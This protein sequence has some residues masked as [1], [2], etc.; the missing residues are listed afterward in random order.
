MAPSTQSQSICYL[1][2]VQFQQVDSRPL[3]L[4]YYN[5]ANPQ[6]PLVGPGGNGTTQFTDRTGALAVQVVAG[7]AAATGNQVT[8]PTTSGW[9]PA[10]VITVA[11]GQTS[12]GAVN[13]AVHPLAPFLASLTSQ[14]HLGIP[15][16]APKV[17]LSKEVQGLLPGSAIATDTSGI[18][19]GVNAEKLDGYRAADLLYNGSFG[20]PLQTGGGLARDN[21]GALGLVWD[22]GTRQ[23]AEVPRADHVHSNDAT[24]GMTGAPF[25]KLGSSVGATSANSTVV[26]ANGADSATT[27]TT[28]TNAS[29]ATSADTATNA[30]YA[31]TAGSA[32]TASNADYATNAGYANSAGT[33]PWADNAGIADSLANQMDGQGGA[34]LT[35]T[36][37]KASGFYNSTL[38]FISINVPS[39]RNY[40]G[41]IA[42]VSGYDGDPGDSGHRPGLSFGGTKITTDEGG[43]F[44]GRVVYFWGE[45]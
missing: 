13:I 44:D 24:G 11:F 9:L 7:A 18:A 26:H 34:G 30:G 37:F 35:E 45:A 17:D 42:Y 4:P 20:Q 8:P 6:V 10:Y 43:N 19:T 16:T 1:V 41:A 39:G 33:S 14:H 40:M 5:S 15:G 38:N 29:H 21:Q 22:D 28:A 12:I 31:T 3:A 36:K 23:H 25:A 32:N 27:A 2:Q